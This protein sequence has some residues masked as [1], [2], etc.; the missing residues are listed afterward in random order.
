MSPS[1]LAVPDKGRETRLA[2]KVCAA[3]K[4]RNTNQ[5]N[6]K[7]AVH[8]ARCA[9][10]L[11]QELTNSAAWGLQRRPQGQA[12][13]KHDKPT[14][15]PARKFWVCPCFGTF[16]GTQSCP[17]G[18]AAVSA[19]HARCGEGRHKCG[20]NGKLHTAPQRLAVR[21]DFYALCISHHLAL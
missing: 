2:A 6:T 8:A 4:A 5:R 18:A 9:G 13:A 17:R 21:H 16:S 15:A 12:L 3:A 20:V 7:A 1:T 14:A 19:W 10:A 11:L